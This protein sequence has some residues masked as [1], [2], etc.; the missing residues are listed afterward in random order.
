MRAISKAMLIASAACCLN[1]SAFAQDISLNVSNV[2]VK[3]AMA[4]L[5]KTSGYSFVFSSADVNT[6]QLVSVSAENATIQEIVNQIL[7][8]Q[9]G[10]DYEIQ[11]KKI[12]L[13]KV[14]LQQPK[15]SKNC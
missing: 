2:T 11:G 1:L 14:Q 12:V 4:Q 6:K 13:K 10:L 9:T 3:E 7:K 8:G 5:K 15:S